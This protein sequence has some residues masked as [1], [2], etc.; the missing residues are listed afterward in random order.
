MTIVGNLVR[1]S[2][3]HV[4]ATWAGSSSYGETVDRGGLT[5]R[6]IGLAIINALNNL[7]R[8]E[9]AFNGDIERVILLV[10]FS[11]DT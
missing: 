9:P 8:D 1:A 5:E 3:V 7:E 4:T 6:D 10:T 11:H 2:C